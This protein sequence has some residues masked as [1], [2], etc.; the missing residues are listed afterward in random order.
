MKGNDEMKKQVFNPYLPSW[1]YVPDG[2][3]YV[4]GDRLYVFGS[5]DEFNGKDFCQ[6]DYVC[7]SAPTADLGDWKLEGTIY[8]TVQDP[9]A[10]KNSFLQAPDVI[11]GPDGRFYLYYTL[12]L[13][14]F[15]GVAVSDR[16]AGPYE[17]YGKVRLPN[18]HVI[19]SKKHELFQFDPGVFRD[20]DGRYYLYSGFA[21]SDKGIMGFFTK[22]YKME[23]AYVMELGEDMLTVKTEPK[24]I[25]PK[26][27]HSAGTGFEGHEFYEASSMRKIDGRYY[28][29]YSSILSHELCYAVSSRPDGDFH[30]G[31]TLVSIGDVGL[32]GNS[33][34]VNYTGNTHGSLVKVKGQWYVF[35]HR[36]TNR[37]LFSRQGCAEP[38]LLEEDGTFRQ[39]EVTSCGLN[40]GPLEGKGEYSAHIACNLMGKDGIYMYDRFRN[41]N[42]KNHPYLT[43]TGK[44]RERDPDQY[45]ANMK[46]GSTAGYKYFMLRD[47]KRLGVQVDGE[48]HGVM[49][50]RTSLDGR[51]LCRIPVTAG[52]KKSWFEAVCMIPDGVHALYFTYKGE[53]SVN[54][55][56]FEFCAGGGD[57]A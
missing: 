28:F 52:A 23:G 30:Y 38:I 47:L 31:G 35:Y 5:H 14:P 33:W 24:V 57:E 46:D 4:Y 40:G 45:I 51:V 55:H 56:R 54:L 19:G 21:P 27:G 12:C 18:G 41:R 16:L 39:A 9:D 2:E 29:I 49:E 50:V 43:Q 53:G 17:Y 22:Q 37:N 36:Q 48:G 15:M 32:H 10:K 3:P 25:I 34:A 20:D 26:T 6:N 1:E 42:W 44:D 7:W 13:A 11:Q 8:R